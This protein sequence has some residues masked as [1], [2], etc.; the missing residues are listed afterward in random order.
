V[1][2]P[3]A[4][5]QFPLVLVLLLATNCSMYATEPFNSLYLS[6]SLGQG[7]MPIGVYYYP[8][9][10]S[11]NQWERDLKHIADLGFA[12]TH[13]AEFAWQKTSCSPMFLKQRS[14]PGSITGIM[15]KKENPMFGVDCDCVAYPQGTGS[16][17][18]EVVD[19]LVIFIRFTN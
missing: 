14:T 10:W 17:R 4:Q 2:N 19:Q 3:E 13:F 9:H 16:L 12:F 6:N 7:D 5:N 18:N 8:E 11:P 15:Q 1:N